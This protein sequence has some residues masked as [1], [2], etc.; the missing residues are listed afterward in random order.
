MKNKKGL[1]DRKLQNNTSHVLLYFLAGYF[2]A[3]NN[4]SYYLGDPFYFAYII[5]KDYYTYTQTDAFRILGTRHI[6]G[7]RELV[8][9]KLEHN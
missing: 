1:V 3:S 5:S 7:A 6:L 9:K 2:Q 4:D 8:L